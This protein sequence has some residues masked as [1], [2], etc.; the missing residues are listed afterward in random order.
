MSVIFE[1]ADRV[2]KSWPLTVVVNVDK[3]KSVLPD[4]VKRFLFGLVFGFPH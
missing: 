3:M 2:G 1:Q 4:V